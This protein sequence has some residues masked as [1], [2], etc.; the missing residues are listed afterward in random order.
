MGLYNYC[1]LTKTPVHDMQCRYS[2]AVEGRIRPSVNVPIP[3]RGW[4]F[5]FKTKQGLVTHIDVTVPLPLDKNWPSIQ[6]NLAEGIKLHINIKTPDLPWIQRELKSLQ[7]L[8]GIFGL[9]SIDLN[10][11]IIQ[12]I[13]ES[14]DEQQKLDLYSFSSKDEHL[15]D[16][17][18]PPLS[19]DLI[20]RAVLASDAASEIEVALNFF[21]R[22]MLDV[23]SHSYIEAI[24]DFYFVLESEFG[25]GKFKKKAILNSFME[26][27]ALRSCIQRA[28]AEPGLMLQNKRT[29]DQFAN[30]YA[31]MTVEDALAQIV[32]LRGY[33]HHHTAKRRDNWHPDEQHHYEV[34]ALFLQSVAYNAVF[35]LAKRYLWDTTVVS[36]YEA[37]AKQYKE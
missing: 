14:E 5:E 1:Q 35:D 12:W 16:E 26:S 9:H 2:F 33:L 30:T 19:F 6:E 29:R 7:G 13:P 28:I 22:G 25:D 18:V 15:P 34:D 17:Q 27:S 36:E 21:R 31:K 10:N 37:L 3:A 24:Y 20:A 4:L 32:E 8:L 23:Y 11:P